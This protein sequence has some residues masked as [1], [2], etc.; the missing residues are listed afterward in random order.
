MKV[1]K[2]LTQLKNNNEN[3]NFSFVRYPDLG[4]H[5]DYSCSITN[6]RGFSQ[7]LWVS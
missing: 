1:I 7:N 2:V 3:N 6:K 4:G 5:F